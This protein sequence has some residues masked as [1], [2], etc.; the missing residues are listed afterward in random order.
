METDGRRING[1]SLE[2]RVNLVGCEASGDISRGNAIS[3]SFLVFSKLKNDYLKRRDVVS[4]MREAM[5]R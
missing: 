4:R 3:D 1:R 5:M 2:K